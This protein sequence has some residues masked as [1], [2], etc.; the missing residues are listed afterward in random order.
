M[1]SSPKSQQ[2]GDVEER[3]LQCGQA[4]LEVLSPSLSSPPLSLS[5][6]GE[7]RV[8]PG[9]RPHPPAGLCLF[10][11]SSLPFVHAVCCVTVSPTWARCLVFLACR[12]QAVSSA[13]PERLIPERTHILWRLFCVFFLFCFALLCLFICLVEVKESQLR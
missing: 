11:P 6:E 13:V 4:P 3:D 9:Q 5:H 12:N 7:A 10:L 2:D 8:C 1:H